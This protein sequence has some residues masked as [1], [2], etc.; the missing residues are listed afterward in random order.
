MIGIAYSVY[1]FFQTSIQA[2]GK[3]HPHNLIHKERDVRVNEEKR[4][5]RSTAQT[6]DFKKVSLEYKYITCKN[7]IPRPTEPKI[8]RC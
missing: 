8:S 7:A 3:Y 4:D 2:A 6:E 1:I 5:I